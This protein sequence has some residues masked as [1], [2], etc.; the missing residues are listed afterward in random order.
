VILTPV[1]H[2]VHEILQD[3]QQQIISLGCEKRQ[4]CSESI[5]ASVVALRRRRCYYLPRCQQRILCATCLVA[6]DLQVPSLAEGVLRPPVADIK[7]LNL[8]LA[9]NSARGLLQPLYLA[10]F[11]L[12]A[13]TESTALAWK[14]RRMR[15]IVVTVFTETFLTLPFLFKKAATGSAP[16]G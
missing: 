10:K 1:L 7:N 6:Q 3:P 12:N 15:S 9:D 8:F 11:P 13:A 14:R 4:L 2:P 16:A 5:T